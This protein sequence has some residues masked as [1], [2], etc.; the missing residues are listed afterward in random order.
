[1]KFND[2]RVIA[3]R[4]STNTDHCITEPR[5]DQCIIAAGNEKFKIY[6]AKRLSTP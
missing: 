3:F 4:C 1:M 5:D 2:F 6:Y